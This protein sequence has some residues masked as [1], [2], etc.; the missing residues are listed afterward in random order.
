MW[1]GR[2]SSAL[3]VLSS[4]AGI[5]SG[6]GAESGFSSLHALSMSCSVKLKSVILFSVLSVAK[7]SDGLDTAQSAL[8]CTNTLLYCSLS[9]SAV[10][11]GSGF[12]SP[13]EG[14]MKGPTLALVCCLALA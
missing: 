6:P 5:P 9:C 4:S 12:G 14:S 1:S 11:S 7:N 2:A 3:A 8:G 10:K 13:D